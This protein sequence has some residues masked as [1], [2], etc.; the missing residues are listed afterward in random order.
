MLTMDL[1]I[2]VGFFMVCRGESKQAVADFY[3]YKSS[4]STGVQYGS[5]LNFPVT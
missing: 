4:G 2:W 5:V 1:L 3:Q